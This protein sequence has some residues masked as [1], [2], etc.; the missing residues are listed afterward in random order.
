MIKSPISPKEAKNIVNKIIP[1][2][3][4]A[5]NEELVKYHNG[6]VTSIYDGN[7]LENMTRSLGLSYSV[8]RLNLPY[9]MSESIKAKYEKVGWLVSRPETLKCNEDPHY[10]FKEAESNGY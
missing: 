8:I 10:I 7:I 1:A 6:S 3:Y 9:K 2:Y 5:I 4:E